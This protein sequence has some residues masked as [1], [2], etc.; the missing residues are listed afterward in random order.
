M[1]LNA[2]V[3]DT[4]SNL[5]ATFATTFNAGIPPGSYI[6][7]PSNTNLLPLSLNPRRSTQVF[8]EY[9]DS[10]TIDAAFDTI[11]N[12]NISTAQLS[13]TTVDNPAFHVTAGMAVELLILR[14][15]TNVPI[16]D[17]FGADPQIVSAYSELAKSIAENEALL[18]RV[19][20]F[21]YGTAP[22]PPTG[23]D[24]SPPT[25]SPSAATARRHVGMLFNWATTFGLLLFSLIRTQA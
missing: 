11:P 6:W 5:L 15:L 13:L 16:L 20:E 25:S 21:V 10:T 8:G 14:T 1:T 7:V 18:Q 23:T 19:K 17:E 24:T 12:T 2:D 9:Y 3:D 4:Y 22:P